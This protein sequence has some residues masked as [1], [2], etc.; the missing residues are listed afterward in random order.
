MQST[1][2]LKIANKIAERDKEFFDSLIEF[3]KNKKDD[4]ENKNG[5]HNRQISSV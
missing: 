2:I 5:I 4:Y 1:K 3:E